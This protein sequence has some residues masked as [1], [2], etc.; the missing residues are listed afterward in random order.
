ML[1]TKQILILI[2]SVFLL[3][4]C[5]KDFER[6]NWD[7]DLLAPLITTTL[8]LEDIL[9]DSVLVT[10][11][12]TSLKVV[13]EESIFDVGVD[14]LFKIPDTTITDIYVV[15]ITSIVAPGGSFYSE[16]EE[17]ALTITNGVG[18]NFAIIESGFIEVEIL[19][20]IQE[21]I[22]VTYVIPSAI[23]NGD[24]LRL[25]E[26]VP[27]GSPGNPTSFKKKIDMS[28]YELDLTGISKSQ[29]NTLVT[30]AV[31]TVDPNAS[32]SVTLNVGDEIVFKNNLIDIVPYFV[33]GYFG[34]Q[35]FSYKDTSDIDVL[36]KI[37]GGLDLD[38]VDVDIEFKNGIGVDAQMV[39]NQFTTQNTTTNIN[40]SLSHSVIG[41]PLNLNRSTLTYST[42]EVN[43]TN[44]NVDINTNNS[45]ID[46]LIEL[47]PN[48]LIY[49]VD[50]IINPLGNISGGN[51]FVYKKH[52]LETNI[53]VEFP[54]SLISNNLALQDT[55][56]FSLPEESETGRI[57]DG[58][59]F[60]Y[61]DNGFPF[62]AKIQLAMYDEFDN[63][64]QTINVDNQILAA[65]VDG[66]LRV[67]S[68]KQSVLSIPLNTSDVDNLY[69][70]KKLLFT[71]AFT[72]QPQSQFIKIYEGYE[73]DLQIVGDFSYNVDL[74]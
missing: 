35:N 55:L 68:K 59:L 8:N 20:E 32:N 27:A 70:A 36:K 10:N 31:G 18:L 9:P 41:T 6:P 2:L 53:K 26:T 16:S 58:T 30:R 40:A 52:V 42:P 14:S 71:I 21:D 72:T 37:S 39:L 45:N 24:T 48:Q 17:Y 69:M 12:D 46:N 1:N 44:Y 54:L 7:V 61:A 49:D 57:L 5:R 51:D 15:P 56:G 29:I 3:F 23:K 66:N 73:I 13:Y 22:I 62:D 33:R 34:Q 11:P 63:Y 60:L 64:I 4:S 50:L 28:G 19:S 38:E 65:P 67:T 43:Y 74:K 47:I 25:V